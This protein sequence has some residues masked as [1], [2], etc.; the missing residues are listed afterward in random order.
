MTFMSETTNML[1]KY[2]DRYVCIFN[3][4]L[5]MIVACCLSN[6]GQNMD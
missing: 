3:Y 2:V 6:F 1:D 4:N 5:V